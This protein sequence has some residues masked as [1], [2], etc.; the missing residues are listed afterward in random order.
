MA[1]LGFAVTL[2]LTPSA[3][4]VTGPAD[5]FRITVV[6]DSTG[7]GVPLVELR[8][9]NKV[10]FHTDSH[11][12]IAFHEPGLMDRN[13]YFEVASHGYEIPKDFLGNRGVRLTPRA[14]D[15]AV[16]RM[17]RRNIAERLYRVTG[18]GI[19]RDS[20]LLGDPA[21]LAQPLLNAQVMGQDTVIAAPYRGKIFWFWGDTDRASHVLGNFAV[22]GATSEPPSKGGLDPSVGVDL[23]YF[24]DAEGG[25]KPMCGELGP[26]MKWIGGLFTLT[27]GSGRE[28]LLATVARMKHLEYAHDWQLA[29]FDDEKEIFES[30][31]RWNVH[32]H[33]VS[34]HPFRVRAGG[35][36][37]FY[38]FPDLRVKA[39]LASLRDLGA[40]EAFTSEAAGSAPYR[41][42]AGARRLDADRW[43]RFHDFES[44]K[45]ISPGWGSV[46][47]NAFRRRW[48]AV[49]GGPPGDVW[50]AEADTPVGPWVYAR[51]VV[52]H[53]R[54]NFY[55]PT[56]HPF[57]DQDGGRVIYFEG[58]YTASFSGAPVKTPRYDYNQI[59]YRL[60]LAD[61]R[62]A[63]PAP[64]YRLRSADGGARYHLRETV[65]GR[66]EWDRIEEVAFF[67][68]PPGRRES[69]LVPV[70]ARDGAR[71]TTLHLHGR[72]S[73]APAF[74]ALP[75]VETPREALP[76]AW[77]CE[78]R[79]DDGGSFAFDLEL[80]VSGE[81]VTGRLND[82][83][84]SV[85]GTLR[86]ERLTLELESDGVPFVLEATY[87]QDR[88][89]GEWNRAD[90]TEK[91][92]WS[93]ERVDCGTKDA[94]APLVVPLYE[95]RHRDGSRLF[96]TTPDLSRPGLTRSTAPLCRVWRNPMPVLVLDREARPVPLETR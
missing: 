18:Q 8:S 89:R 57:F 38:L 56:Q 6:D 78:A 74:L 29:L 79:T 68:V 45:P 82:A 28:R 84:D 91:G 83:P 37:Y 54:Y 96:A 73:E 65:D 55:N 48:V 35:V 69:G 51:R 1:A 92:S 90:S 7:R 61:P 77:R 94:Q 60:D 20:A 87:A 19:Y 5:Y 71:G 3:Q 64:V 46:A 58:T 42:K 17:R 14:G 31:A 4:P 52:S 81:N 53:D 63:L 70:F 11:G 50:F 93:A 22:S 12:V 88:L 26:G 36:D 16:I 40:Y 15:R 9:V 62:L 59:L 27:D 32:D 34:A 86:S 25:A 67:A 44:G 10:T 2:C 47:W 85:R 76:G 66:G 30:V 41:W 80:S 39:D 72:P 13:V 95:Y 43:T 24:V 21:P 75:A 33:H 49:S 23:R